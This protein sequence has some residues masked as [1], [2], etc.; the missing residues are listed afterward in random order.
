MARVSLTS[1]GVQI[2]QRLRTRT[3]YWAS[4]QGARGAGAQLRLTLHDG[5]ERRVQ[6]ADAVGLAAQIEAVVVAPPAAET[7]ADLREGLAAFVARVG[8]AAAPLASYLLHSAAA[9]NASDLHLEPD[10]TGA[11]TI[12]LRIDGVVHR[13]GPMM[14]T[15]AR[16]LVGRLKVLAGVQVHRTDL[17]Q[18]GRAPLAAGWVRLG[19]VPAFESE[20]VTARLFDRLKGEADVSNLGFSAAQ[21]STLDALL[22]APQ[23]VLLFAGPSASGKTTTLY[24]ALRRLLASAGGTLRALTI[25]DPVEYALPGVTQLEVGPRA[26]GD[27]LLRSA[28]R[29]DADVLVV[30]E[31]RAAQTVD[32]L[33]RAG[34]T[35]HRVLS[36]VHA[37]GA[38]EALLRLMERGASAELVGTAVRGV[39]AQRLVRRRC[40]STG[41]ARCNH[42]GYRG[43]VAVVEM[44]QMTDAVRGALGLNAGALRAAAGLATARALGEAVAQA[45]LTDAAEVD[46]V[47]GRAA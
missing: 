46:R 22:A 28:L 24:T 5:P 2:T 16:R 12:S 32:L 23:G 9:L 18:D 38:A 17:P 47:F 10:A 34:I 39:I 26:D 19:F 14:A 3:L 37:G 20:A 29:Q 11:A 30:G 42:T 27:T 8:F 6:V 43:R 13:V 21:I 7:L 41:C 31:V 45:G 44:L 25:E 40:C 4:V 35:G 33:L 1:E 36:T 15:R